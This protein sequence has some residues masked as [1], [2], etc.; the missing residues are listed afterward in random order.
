MCCLGTNVLANGA[1][2]SDRARRCM[3]DTIQ[4]SKSVGTCPLTRWIG[5]AHCAQ[6]KDSC[7]A[8][9]LCRGDLR[10]ALFVPTDVRA[11]A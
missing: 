4:M 2:T 11:C 8:P 6:A 1:D 10:E 5:A 7:Q 3:R 9:L